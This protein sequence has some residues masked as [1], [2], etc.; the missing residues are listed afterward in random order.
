[1]ICCW[2]AKLDGRAGLL[3]RKQQPGTKAQLTCV[4]K[5]TLLVVGAAAIALPVKARRS[6][7]CGG[8]KRQEKRSLKKEASSRH[9]DNPVERPSLLKE[10]DHHGGCM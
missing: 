1:M 8:M 2:L 6:T 3:N 10:A 7:C 5:D 9:N 4:V